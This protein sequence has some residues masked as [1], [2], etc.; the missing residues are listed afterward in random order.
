MTRGIF[1]YLEELQN[2]LFVLKPA[3]IEQKYFDICRE[4]ADLK[5]INK[6]YR[7]SMEDY[8]NSLEEN[9]KAALEH[10]TD[11]VK[12]IYFEYD[13]DNNWDGNYYLCQEYNEL[14]EEDDDWACEWEIYIQGPDFYEFSEMY[15]MKGGFGDEKE[16]IGITLFLIVRTMTLFLGLAKKYDTHIPVCIAYH[17]QDPIMRTKKG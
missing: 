4:L 6:I 17:D 14:S 12:A 11:D 10:I 2:D 9:L 3:D 1:S 7:I 15:Q 8:K 5:E 16:E 13:I